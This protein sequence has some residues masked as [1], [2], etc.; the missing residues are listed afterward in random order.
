MILIQRLPG[1]GV[2]RSDENSRTFIDHAFADVCRAGDLIEFVGSPYE[3]DPDVLSDMASSIGMLGIEVAAHRAT[4][5][6]YNEG[7]INAALARAK[8]SE[9]GYLTAD[10]ARLVIECH[11]NVRDKL[12]IRGIIIS[13]IELDTKADMSKIQFRDCFFQR[14]EID[15][16]A[17]TNRL[18][19]F[20]ES[21]IEELD[22]RISYKDLP[23]AIFDEKCHIDTFSA[24]AETT[25][26]VLSLGLPLGVKVC[27]SILKKLYEQRGA[28][29]KENALHRGLDNHAR[30]LVPDVLRVLQ[31]EGLAAPDRSRGA[32]IWRPDRSSRTR[33]G[34]MISAPATDKDAVLRQC[35]TL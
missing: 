15:P 30:R 16:D 5:S 12:T 22:G 27:V 33:V 31:S 20:S 11:L 3:F 24:S 17:D 2:D 4:Q 26:A 7:I 25:A 13:E 1:L 32:V 34:R 6:G 10:L 23:K 29:R 28:G 18:P 8:R 9:D 35:G 19:T 21:I 14:V